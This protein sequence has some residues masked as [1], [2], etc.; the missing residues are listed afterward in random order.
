M[1]RTRQDQDPTTSSPPSTSSPSANANHRPFKARRLSAH[2][3]LSHQTQIM[4]AV[5]R[6]SAL[7]SL[8]ISIPPSPTEPLAAGA[9]GPLESQHPGKDSVR[10]ER[11][12][13]VTFSDP[14]EEED[15][16]LSDQSSICQ[17]PSWE[18]YKKKKPKKRGT[19]QDRKDKEE[20]LLKKKGN[21]LS[22]APPQDVQRVNQ[23]TTTDW[24][25]SAPH[26]ES[27]VKPESE[28]PSIS[29]PALKET[30]TNRQLTGKGPVQEVNGKPKS[31][32]FLS[33]FRLQHGNVSTVQK[34]IETS[35]V[36]V[37]DD[38]SL[39]G[40]D[41][42][43]TNPRKP[44]SIRSVISTSTRSNSSQEKQPPSARYFAGSGHGRSQSLLSSTL[45]KLR[46]PS[47]LYYHPTEDGSS[48]QTKR[49]GSARAAGAVNE[50][51]SDT[52]KPQRPERQKEDPKPTIDSAQQPPDFVFPP[53]PKQAD[54]EPGPE[55]A[56]R[57][58]KIRV[59]AGESR[60]ASR[61]RES[62]TPVRSKDRRVHA[63]PAQASKRDSVM[64]MV[65]AQ[66]KQSRTERLTQQARSYTEV[67]SRLEDRTK[68]PRNRNQEVDIQVNSYVQL[69]ADVR[70]DPKPVPGFDEEMDRLDVEHGAHQE[71]DEISVGT[72]ASTIRPPSRSQDRT[73][74]EA[75][76]RHV[77]SPA[78][79]IPTT[80]GRAV[81]TEELKESGSPHI[82]E[83]IEDHGLGILDSKG[84]KTTQTQ[85]PRRQE[86]SADYLAFIS[87]SYAPPS[88]ELRSLSED[89]FPSAHIPE[90]AE[91]S[92]SEAEDDYEDDDDFFKNHPLKH[93][94]NE[95]AVAREQ[96][97]QA[98]HHVVT[99]QANG[100]GKVPSELKP[101]NSP[102]ISAHYSDSDLPVFERLGIS[103]KAAR[104]LAGIETESTSTSRSHQ[105][106]PSHSTSE[107][108]SSSTYDDAPPSPSSATTPDSSR[109]QSRKGTVPFP[110]DAPQS[111]FA[112][113]STTHD[114]RK[115]QKTNRPQPIEFQAARDYQSTGRDSK[116][117]DDS[118]S[119]TAMPIDL[120]HQSTSTFDRIKGLVSTPSLVGGPNS[121]TFADVLKEGVDEDGLAKRKPDRSPLPPRA[122]S[123]LEIHSTMKGLPPHKNQPSFTKHLKNG[124][125]SNGLP[126]S[127]PVEPFDEVHPRKSALKLPRN[128]TS[129]S[130]DPQTIVSQG[131]A[132]L[133]EARKNVP[134]S[135][136]S[137]SR[138]LR[139]HFAHKDSSGS[140]K[141]AGPSDRRAEP[142]AK[143][144]VECCNC[145]FFHDMPSRVYECMA[146]PDSIVEDKLLGVSAAITTMVKCPWCG[147]GMTTQCCAGYATV[148]YLKEKLHGK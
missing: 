93:S 25:R 13:T 68:K 146:K 139:P 84:A 43:P 11:A 70:E 65:M 129:D 35:Q 86:R 127:P 136:N 15:I 119:R 89:K 29:K 19:S 148:V 82:F 88:L 28:N 23:L 37:D 123:A 34:I 78:S 102:A 96:T 24:S 55:I 115:S 30:M 117:Q 2:P 111:T 73:I 52:P 26:L 63:E 14:E 107:R 83:S 80:I 17:S 22:K 40:A 9:D 85:H 50:K 59:Q 130:Q 10:E 27:Y 113:S 124:T 75:N 99:S 64:A 128:N 57:A 31:K 56:P 132:Y 4:K 137:S 98:A 108:S 77:A 138:A 126:S 104:I 51:L 7:P 61:D 92:E 32:G 97:K 140:I 58:R 143:M 42:N 39:Q 71:D 116:L 145:K 62:P 121:V 41:S 21:R 60:D 81:T 94:I 79:P 66:E 101:K 87:E 36:S 18:Q 3:P 1:Q 144:L 16:N 106:E 100:T 133:Q 122:Q 47:Y 69:P 8:S 6:S 134:A 44:P 48:N 142:L 72:H 147:H 53:K 54:N 90:K 49:P 95:T 131:A 118:W 109:P 141:N 74:S 12:K 114:E 76:K 33:G 103:P 20:N 112:I 91:E 135:S 125:A 110:T 67:P 120:G 45:N 105:T 5:R 46:G 38:R